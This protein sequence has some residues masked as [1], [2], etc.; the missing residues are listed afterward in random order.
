MTA[1][2][3]YDHLEP[4]PDFERL[5]I[6]IRLTTSRS[7]SVFRLLMLAPMMVM[8]AVPLS[9]IGARA[10][11]E[12]S[13]LDHLVSNPLSAIQIIAGFAIWTILFLWPI[14][15]VVTRMGASR[16][17]DIDSATV[18]VVDRSPFGSR[19]WAEPLAN[20]AGITHHIRASLSGNRHELILVHVDASKNVLI[21]IADR[22]TQTTIDR[23]K[24]LLNLPEVPARQLYRTA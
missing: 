20:Y 24:A 7:S 14:K 11:S 17:I 18:T 9:L 13:A 3:S 23:A 4:T 6:S 15:R 5:P 21:S 12:T 19:M 8:L 16:T 1:A 2:I 10:A 22:M